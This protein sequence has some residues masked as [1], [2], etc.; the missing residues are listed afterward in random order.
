MKNSRHIAGPM[1]SRRRRRLDKFVGRRLATAACA[2]LVGAIGI[3]TVDDTAA[4][5]T[6]TRR[7]RVDAAAAP[8]G[9][10]HAH[11]PH[12]GPARCLR[13]PAE[14][15]GREARC[16]PRASWPRP[17]TSSS[18]AQAAGARPRTTTCERR[19][20]PSRPPARSQA[21]AGP[22]SRL[23]SPLAKPAAKPAVEHQVQLTLMQTS[24]RRVSG[25]GHRLPRR[26]RGRRA[27]RRRPPRPSRSSA[28]SCSR[29]AGAAS[30]PTS[31]LNQLNASAGSG[32]LAV[33]EDLF[34]L[35]DRMRAGLA[36]SRAGSSIPTVLSLDDRAG[37]RRGLRHGQRPRPR[38]RCSTT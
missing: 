27:R 19:R 36:M 4:A 5:A 28:S 35:V 13:R 34:L 23:R 2:G 3:R 10:D 30:A 7:P 8:T 22:P 29:S 31:E 24:E 16:L 18:A 6:R 25:D 12:R 32:P 11:G 14:G 9:S 37:L 15:R 38:Q 17:P 20:A 33:R 21:E 26:R 1:R